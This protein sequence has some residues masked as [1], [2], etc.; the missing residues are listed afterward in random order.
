MIA[1]EKQLDV[2]WVE[3]IDIHTLSK[4]LKEYRYFV[5]RFT[6]WVGLII[7]KAEDERIRHLLLPNFIEE[8]GNLD[9]AISHLKMLD[10]LLVS[11]GIKNIEEYKP[12]PSTIDMERW[13]YNLFDSGDTYASLCAIGP[14]TEEIS[15]EFL[16]P[17]FKVVKRLFVDK[18]INLTY[19]EAH[20]SAMEVEHV[21]AIHAAIEYMEQ[22]NPLLNNQMNKWVAAS[23]SKHQYFWSSLKVAFL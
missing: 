21:R 5:H 2:K 16:Q 8:S 22:K 14:A 3:A 20:L 10:N 9:G 15:G 18:N 1:I 6:S 12:L 17:I 23:I 4:V 11:C 7:S 13:F 19:F